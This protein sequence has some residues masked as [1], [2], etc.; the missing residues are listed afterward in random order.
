M[1]NTPSPVR[2]VRPRL[3]PRPPPSRRAARAAAR[4]AW[5]AQIAPDSL[6]HRLFDCLPG[7]RF[8]AKNRRGEIMIL[9]GASRRL[10]GI[11]DEAAVI[12]LTDFDLSPAGMARGYVRDDARIYATGRPLLN[13]VELWWDELG[14][15]DW[16]V[17][18]K[19][20]IRSRRGRIIGIMG[21]LQTYEG[22]RRL[23]QPVG[24]IARA[25]DFLRAS[26]SRP[27]TIAQV[28]RAASLSI[29]QLQRR[30]RDAF[31]IGPQEYLVKTRVL[32]AI[33]LLR[34]TDRS[35]AEIALDCGFCDQS[36]F[37]SHFRRCVGTTPSRFRRGA[38][39]H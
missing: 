8:F 28:A 37:T 24:G 17:V 39:A 36:A 29:R 1:R 9:D 16:C 20:P 5:L 30:F 32:A 35:L 25:V 2:A 31:G 23:L 13:H 27:V 38:G 15:P 22:R 34:G 19:L 33:R 6:F 14:M 12:G 18:N 4:D 11:A 3:P 7:V 21:I 26:C 10:Y